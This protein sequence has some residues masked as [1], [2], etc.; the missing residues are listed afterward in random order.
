MIPARSGPAR[1]AR[2]EPICYLSYWAIARPIPRLIMAALRDRT[3]LQQRRG[4]HRVARG[5]PAPAWVAGRQ[6]LQ[7]LHVIPGRETAS[8][9]SLPLHGACVTSASQTS[10]EQSS[11]VTRLSWICLG[12]QPLTRHDGSCMIF[13]HEQPDFDAVGNPA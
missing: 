1:D 3:G 10:S 6:W 5:W 8:Q 7:R 9:T 11:F 12:W 2:C 13:R 4:Q